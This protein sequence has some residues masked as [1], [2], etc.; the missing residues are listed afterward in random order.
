MRNQWRTQKISVGVGK[1]SSQ[2]CDVTI[3]FRGSAGGD[4]G[5]TPEK[6]L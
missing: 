2:L 4:R 1:I 5:H 3:N 6:I